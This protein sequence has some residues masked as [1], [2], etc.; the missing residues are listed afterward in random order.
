MKYTN[1]FFQLEIKENGVYVHIYPEREGGKKIV[2]QEL[3]E[4]LERCG[5]KGYNL[6][7]LNSAISK[8]KEETTLFVTSNTIPEVNE[9]AK[10]RITDDRMMVFIRFY[11]PSKNGKPMNEKDI[12]NELAAYKITYGI[13]PKIIQAYL[14]G[15]QYCRD[16]PIAKGKAVVPGRDAK[17][18]YKFDTSPTA[19]PQLLEDGSVDFHQL[20]IFTSV[21]SGDLLAELIPAVEGEPGIDVFGNPVPP[22]KIRNAMLK[23]GRNI[24]MNDEK[25]Q[26]FSEVDGDVKLEG[27]TVFVSN[28]Y[29]VPAD[30]DTSTGDIHYA[31][32]VHVTGN[33]RSGFVVEASGDVEINGVVEGATIIAGGNIVL[34]RGAQGM[35]K[36]VLEAGNDIVAKFLESCNVKAGN[37]INTGSSL[38]CDLIAGNEVIVSGRKGFLIGGTIAAGN[39]IEASVF[40]NKMNTNTILRVGVE[41]EKME[42]Y[43]DLTISIKEKQEEMT[44]LKQTLE[45]FKKKV[46]E[47]Q[48]LLPNQLVVL[49]Q[50]SQEFKTISEELETE[51]SEYMVLKEEIDSK[52]GGKVVVNHTIFPGVCIYISNR[53]YPVKDIRSR[54]QFRVAGADVAIVP[55]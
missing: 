42:R 12:M 22:L 11:P 45:T 29:V 14:M 24:R 25:T 40:G 1:A 16:I 44:K 31:G 52:T 35:G 8:I 33:V 9:M 15:R 51:S 5:V 46:A 21:H 48:K 23:H 27:D 39:K 3:A 7:E 17:I 19:K 13:S 38:H 32:N 49:K 2:I 18:I 41:P 4:Y 26:I 55:I 6:P 34:K 28:T 43:K 37:V 47:G 30:V 10:V 20:N 36:G 53:V 50:T 54:C